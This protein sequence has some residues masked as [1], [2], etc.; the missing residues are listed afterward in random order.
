MN[1]SVTALF[2]DDDSE[3]RLHAERLAAAGLECVGIAPPKELKDLVALIKAAVSDE[4]CGAVLLDYRLDATVVEPHGGRVPYRGAQAAAAIRE[5]IPGLPLVLVTTE[6]KLRATLA[7]SPG[8]RGLFDHEVLKKRLVSRAERKQVALELTELAVG[9]QEIREAN[10]SDWA[11]MASLLSARPEDLGD[12]A[13]SRLPVGVAGTAGWL[14]EELLGLPGPLIDEDSAAALLGVVV[15]AFRRPELQEAVA[16]TRYCGPFASWHPRWWRVGLE[17]WLATLGGEPGDPTEDDRSRRIGSALQ[18]SGHVVRTS[19]C[20]W[21][22]GR[23]VVHACSLCREPV[24]AA[25]ALVTVDDRPHWAD[26][27]VACYSC[28]QSGRADG[29]PFLPGSDAI[30]Q[31][32]VTGKLRA[33]DRDG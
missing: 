21:C 3:D 24:D 23:D 10:P 4:G 9:F 30:V 27:P 11:G 17:R 8:L 14:I 28:I 5:Q 13:R 20:T 7:Q 26:R 25:H 19:T 33:G 29:L 6:P 22:R 15:S 12:V 2:V 1:G 31:A 18:L 16:A 32:L